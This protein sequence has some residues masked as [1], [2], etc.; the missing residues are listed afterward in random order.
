ML[1]G[2]HR[3]LKSQESWGSGAK[4]RGSGAK[5]GGSVAKIGGSVT[6]FEASVAVFQASGF[7]IGTIRREFGP[8]GPLSGHLGSRLMALG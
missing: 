3:G 5:N 6:K 2:Q 7:R 4:N 8:L 1:W